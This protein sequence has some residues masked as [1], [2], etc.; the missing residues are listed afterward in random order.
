[1]QAGDKNTSFFHNS[2]K[3]RIIKN[4]IEKITGSEGQE[5]KGQEEIKNEAFKHYKNLLTA[6]E[7]QANPEE[8]LRH[9]PRII[10]NNSNILLTKEVTKE[11]VK[12]AVWALQSDKAPGLDD[13][14]IDFYRT[15]WYII[16]KDLMKMIRYVMRKRKI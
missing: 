12:A 8:F 3:T 4:N 5:L 15:F 11:E 6:P 14:P 1:M 10:A 9:I 2:A 13:F 16:K 7:S